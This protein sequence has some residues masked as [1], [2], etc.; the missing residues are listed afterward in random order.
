M[1]FVAENGRSSK[2]DETDRKLSADSDVVEQASYEGEVESVPVE[3][4]YDDDDSDDYDDDDECDEDSDDDDDDD[5]GE[6]DEGADDAA[7]ADID[8]VDGSERRHCSDMVKNDDD[9]NDR[10]CGSSLRE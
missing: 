4:E 6:D 7:A 5:N 1:L 8:G 9:I 3:D 10:L 2:V